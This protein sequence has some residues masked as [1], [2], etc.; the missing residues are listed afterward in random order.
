MRM[1]EEPA[2]IS[3]HIWKYTYGQ[4]DRVLNPVLTGALVHAAWLRGTDRLRYSMM[5]DAT[6]LVRMTAEAGIGK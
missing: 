1:I 5:W 3:D 4:I 6:E 2:A